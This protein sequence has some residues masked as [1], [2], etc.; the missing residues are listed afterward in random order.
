[1]LGERASNHGRCKGKRKKQSPQ[2]AMAPMVKI[3]R[4]IDGFS[5]SQMQ[6]GSR[7]SFLFPQSRASRIV[8]LLAFKK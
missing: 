3:Q 6:S 4:Q 5:S 2:Q 7:D 8:T 1:M